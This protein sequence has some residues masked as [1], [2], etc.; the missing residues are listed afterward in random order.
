MAARNLGAAHAVPADILAL[1]VSLA[2]VGAHPPATAGTDAA[3]GGVHVRGRC[4]EKQ[5]DRGETRGDDDDSSGHPRSP[6][7]PNL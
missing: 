5:R 1:R 4:Q 3:P 6:N 7:A 2:F